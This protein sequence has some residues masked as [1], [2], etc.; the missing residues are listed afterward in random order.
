MNIFADVHDFFVYQ[1]TFKERSC[2]TQLHTRTP[3]LALMFL[4]LSLLSVILSA[5]RS[6]GLRNHSRARHD[7]S[8]NSLGNFVPF[9]SEV[10]CG[11]FL[12]DSAKIAASAQ[13]TSQLFSTAVFSQ[14]FSAPSAMHPQLLRINALSSGRTYVYTYAQ[15]AAQI[16]GS[17][18]PSPWRFFWGNPQLCYSYFLIKNHE[19][20]STNSHHARVRERK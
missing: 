11:F 1:T 19:H 10:P 20:P 15:F 6:R 14:A 13:R 12:G 18:F 3:I 8:C 4:A 2:I 7:G 9:N 16:Y 17:P 5:R